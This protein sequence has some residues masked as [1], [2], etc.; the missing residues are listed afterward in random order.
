MKKLNNSKKAFYA[1]SILVL[2]LIISPLSLASFDYFPTDGWRMS[3]PEKQGMHSE[4]LLKMMESIKES[5]LA[6]Q[7]VTVVRNGYIVLDSYIHPYKDGEKHKMYS[8]T[9]SVASALIGIAIDKGFIEGVDR[10]VIEFFPD[11]EILNLD[12]RK[13]SMTLKN[14]LTMTSGLQANDGWEKNWAGVF[15][16]M[17]SNDWTQYALNLPMEAAPSYECS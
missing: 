14:L 7:N 10:K 8:V 2:F 13:K 12:D 3:T 1:V 17:K 4:N 15:E 5:Q 11:K 9:K 16:M 6:I